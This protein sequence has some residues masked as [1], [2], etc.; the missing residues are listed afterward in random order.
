MSLPNSAAEICY[1][2]ANWT[3]TDGR[4]CSHFAHTVCNATYFKARSNATWSTDGIAML[5]KRESDQDMTVLIS[6]VGALN[7]LDACCACGGGGRQKEA[8]QRCSHVKIMPTDETEGG[9]EPTSELMRTTQLDLTQAGQEGPLCA[10]CRS[11]WIMQKDGTCARCTLQDA[12]GQVWA[13]VGVLVIS[14]VLNLRE[15]R[16]QMRTEAVDRA[17]RNLRASED[18]DH[19]LL[20]SN[21]GNAKHEQLVDIMM[22]Q[23]AKA[24]HDEEAWLRDKPVG[25]SVSPQARLAAIEELKTIVEKRASNVSS[26]VGDMLTTIAYIYRVHPKLPDSKGQHLVGRVLTVRNVIEVLT[27]SKAIASACVLL[28]CVLVV[29][30]VTFHGRFMEWGLHPELAVLVTPCGILLVAEVR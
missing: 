24:L 20:F 2:A 11:Q 8:I 30:V 5:F 28:T 1:D 15:M 17:I 10:G 6:D 13:L 23:S 3:S 16:M 9:V 29:N 4:T 12:K 26:S 7:P 21:L 14:V 27:H 22:Q 25:D 19:R 18:S